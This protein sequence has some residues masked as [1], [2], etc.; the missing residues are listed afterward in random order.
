MKKSVL[1]FVGVFLLGTSSYAL[2]QF[3]YNGLPPPL[4]EP[5]G[6]DPPPPGEPDGP[7]PPPPGPP[8]SPIDLYI[9]L[10]IVGGV[11]VGFMKLKNKTSTI[12]FK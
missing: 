10:L 6:P 3:N 12:N 11:I 2:S 5:D 9:P 7:D 4:G 8:A 1:L